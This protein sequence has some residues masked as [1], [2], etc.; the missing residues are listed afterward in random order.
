MQFISDVLLIS[1]ALGAGVYCFVLSR[2]LSRFTD[3]EKGVG[4]A[5]AVLSVQVDELQAALRNAEEAANKSANT[6]M[7]HTERAE[8]VAQ[9]LNHMIPTGKQLSEHSSL[10]KDDKPLKLRPRRRKPITNQLEGSPA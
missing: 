7:E 8:E 1:A 9:R 3:L 4:G 6:L 2:R 10:G 5:V